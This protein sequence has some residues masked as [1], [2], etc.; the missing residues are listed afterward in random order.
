MLDK[1]KH[2]LI[3]LIVMNYGKECLRGLLWR[4]FGLTLIVS[5]NS[6]LILTWTVGETWESAAW[7]VEEF[8]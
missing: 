6:C 8:L 1:K 3:L 5:F 4:P 2:S 7:L